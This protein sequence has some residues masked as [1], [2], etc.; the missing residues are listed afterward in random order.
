MSKIHQAKEP[1][2]GSLCKNF[3]FIAIIILFLSNIAQSQ[4]LDDFAKV[5]YPTNYEEFTGQQKIDWLKENAW[6]NRN[7]S[8]ELAFKYALEALQLAKTINDHNNIAT[9]YNYLGVIHRNIGDLERA[10]DYYGKA[11]EEAA[12]HHVLIELGYALNNLGEINQ[13]QAKYP[14]AI[15]YINEALKHFKVIGNPM[16]IGYSYN[17]LSQTYLSMQNMDSAMHYQKLS[18]D[19]RLAIQD[20]AGISNSLGTIGKIYLLMGSPQFAM[21][22]IQ[23]SLDLQIKLGDELGVAQSY[24]SL[25]DYYLENGDVQRARQ[26]LHDAIEIGQKVR[27]PIRVRDASRSL[28]DLYGQ[29]GKYEEA[30]NFYRLFKQMDDTLNLR[31]QLVKATEMNLR[32]QFDKEIQEREHLE[33]LARN[34]RMEEQR[35]DRMI[36]VVLLFVLVFVLVVGFSQYKNKTRLS[37]INEALKERKKELEIKSLELEKANADKDRFFSIIA[38]D[39]RNPFH[40]IM[41]F[42][43][44]LL[45]NKEYI[46]GPK[47]E[48]F[49]ERI[50]SSSQNTYVLLENLLEWS[51]AQT[52]SL[53]VIKTKFDLI[54]AVR[55]SIDL[56]KEVAKEKGIELRQEVEPEAMVFADF[57]MID[58]I[59]RNLVS[60]ALKFTAKSGMVRVFCTEELLFFRLTVKDNGVGIEARYLESIFLYNGHSSAGTNKEKGSGLGLV[61]CSDFI[62]LNGG[63]IGVSSQ[64]GLGSE[65]YILIPKMPKHQA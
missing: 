62:K 31:D 32:Y 39:L 8:P 60:N 64:V 55:N 57:N 24:I 11:R 7:N 48:E 44:L 56:L 23:Q 53:K 29:L 61:L 33:E 25:G 65:F 51:R 63:E 59:I 12:A 30:Y 13:L 43:K 42:S 20:S 17:Q 50:Y 19:I 47:L 3:F 41:G 18:L 21:D 28:S 54:D 26:Y 16:G 22:K 27:S 36:Q 4:D 1:S 15:D 38:H 52:G 40:T 35:S 9:L 10:L 49:L 37:L 2:V 5:R 14:L 58:T 6:H 45:D 46:R 34:H